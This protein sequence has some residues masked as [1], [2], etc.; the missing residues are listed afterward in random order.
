[1]LIDV[2]HPE[3]DTEIMELLDIAYEIAYKDSPTR[4]RTPL[5]IEIIESKRRELEN[6]LL[7]RKRKRKKKKKK[8]THISILGKI[9]Q[10]KNIIKQNCL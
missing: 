7:Q 5:D 10:N 4:T 9:G 2:G 8:I 3:N 1:M 6:K